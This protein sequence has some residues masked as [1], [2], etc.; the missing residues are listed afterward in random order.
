M[1]FLLE[2]GSF[3]LDLTCKN[4]LKRKNNGGTF[5]NVATVPVDNIFATQID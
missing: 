1:I 2:R 5:Q 3:E 4:Q